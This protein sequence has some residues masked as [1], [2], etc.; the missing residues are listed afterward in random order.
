ML[1]SS[2]PLRQYRCRIRNSAISGMMVTRPPITT[3][4]NSCA[5]PL[6]CARWDHSPSP[7]VS[8]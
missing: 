4:G 6:F 7:T 8:G 1:P 3:I 2:S 5:L